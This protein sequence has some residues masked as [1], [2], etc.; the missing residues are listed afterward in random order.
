LLR[1]LGE[2]DEQGPGNTRAEKTR[3]QNGRSQI[4]QELIA[5]SKTTE[6]RAQWI[7]Q[8]ADGMALAVQSGG[9]PDGLERLKAMESQQYKA[10][11]TSKLV[12]YITYRRISADYSLRLQTASNDKRQEAQKWYSEQLEG[13]WKAYPSSEDTPDVLMQLALGNEYQNN[14]AEA[15]KWYG[16]LVRQ[17]GKTANGRK[18]QG[19][20][21]RLSMEGKMFAMSGPAIEGGKLD[22]SAYKG[23]VTLVVYWAT[24]CTPCTADMPL[25]IAL[26]DTYKKNGF[27]VMGVNMDPKGSDA[28]IS[29]YKKKYKIA[30]NSLSEPE[31]LDG[32]LGLSYGIVSAPTMFL[33]GK[34]GRVLRRSVSI[35]DLKRE[36]PDFLK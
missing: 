11:R 9:Y 24:W 20:L 34:D 35:T 4:L 19:A 5:A 21:K 15:K 28:K 30:F 12:P 2:W 25:L 7:R 14:I 3:Y 32:P 13:Y 17:F 6:D 18:A 29:A 23:R 16:Q 8:M 33:I 27:E 26:Y 1:K 31:G 22:I 36:L 10:D